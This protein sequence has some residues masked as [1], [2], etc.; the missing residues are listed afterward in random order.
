MK[1]FQL[2]YRRNNFTGVKTTNTKELREAAGLSQ[3]DLA[4]MLGL[5]RS[6][7]AKW[8]GGASRP[9]AS[10]LPALAAAL[11]CSIDDLFRPVPER[12]ASPAADAGTAEA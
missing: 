11:G 1:L 9:T 4:R 5:D 2:Y 7:I 3:E 6:T 10:K 12:A 8:E